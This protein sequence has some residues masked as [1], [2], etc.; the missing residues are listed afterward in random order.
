VRGRLTCT[1]VVVSTLAACTSSPTTVTVELADDPPT[2]ISYRSGSSAW[3]TPTATTGGT[4]AT[5]QYKLE[6][7]DDDYE[8][9]VVGILT[10]DNNPED[11]FAYEL[12]AT[13]ADGTQWYLARTGAV[14]VK[15]APPVPAATDAT[16]GYCTEPGEAQYYSGGIVVSGTVVQPAQV[17]LGSYCEVP[18]GST[19]S[20]TYAINSPPGTEDLLVSDGVDIAVMRSLALPGSTTLPAIDLTTAGQPFAS[21]SVTVRNTGIDVSDDVPVNSQLT[22]YTA[23]G[24]AVVATGDNET[25]G[26]SHAVPLM[27]SALLDQTDVQELAVSVQDTSGA[28]RSG[29]TS[30]PT[31]VSEMTLIAIPGATA[32]FGAGGVSA[33]WQGSLGGIDWVNLSSQS[34]EGIVA[35][36]Y[37]QQNVTT[38]SRWVAAHN[39]T[40]LEF[41]SSAP[42]YEPSWLVGSDGSATLSIGAVDTAFPFEVTTS[43]PLTY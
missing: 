25:P 9:V 11:I 42:G 14:D 35:A 28:T 40:R 6:V 17:T 24:G 43:R 8:V 5:H 1:G 12:Q 10:Y 34:G 20:W 13:S 3:H 19:G 18:P 23:H 32:T 16:N 36:P 39:A 21:Q 15:L 41:D 22:L 31:K 27:P 38:T 7:T 4:Y 37:I 30:S 33:A 29:W 2:F 26:V